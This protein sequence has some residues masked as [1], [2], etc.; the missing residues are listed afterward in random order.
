MKKLKLGLITLALCISALGQN[1]ISPVKP[2]EQ[3]KVKPLIAAE[4]KAREVLNTKIAALP[5][6]KA[7]REAE[8]ALK[9][10]GEVLNAA[11]DK[12]P[13]TSAWRL[14][15]AQTLDEVYRIMAAHSLSSREFKP[16]LD[17]KGDLVFTKIPPPKVP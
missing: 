1:S 16:E 15:S 7:Y 4:T 5:E 14:A 3:L 13:E 11:A 2:E 17:P 6:A 10:A 8:E 12:L 9:K